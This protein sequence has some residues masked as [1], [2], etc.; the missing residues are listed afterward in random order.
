[1]PKST[2]QGWHSVT[3]RIVVHDPAGLIR[4]LRRTFDAVGEFVAV[5]PSQMR[6]GDSIIMVSGAGPRELRPAFLYVYVDDVDRTYQRAL[7][8]GAVSL[9][10]PRIVPYGDRRAMVTDPF[11]NDWQIATHLGGD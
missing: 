10:E 1:M 9:E 2:P 4:F 8:A 6:I 3:P 5:A 11:G 7:Q